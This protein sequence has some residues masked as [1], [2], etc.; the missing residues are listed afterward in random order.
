MSHQMHVAHFGSKRSQSVQCVYQIL[1]LCGV[2]YTHRDW[3]LILNLELA[4]KT[5][6]PD[7]VVAW[8]VV[9][10]RHTPQWLDAKRMYTEH[11]HTCART[12]MHVWTPTLIQ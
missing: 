4:S 1:V 2:W 11:M 12:Y 10:A 6:K 5:G 8:E 7:D 3:Y 9:Y